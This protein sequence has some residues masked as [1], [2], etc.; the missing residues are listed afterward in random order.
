MKKK[1][2]MTNTRATP[3]TRSMPL[4][5][6]SLSLSLSLSLSQPYFS[7]TYIITCSMAVPNQICALPAISLHYRTHIMAS[8]QISPESGGCAVL[9]FNRREEGM[10]VTRFHSN[11]GIQFCNRF[12]SIQ[13]CNRFHLFS[14]G[15]SLNLLRKQMGKKVGVLCCKINF[16][17]I[18]DE[19]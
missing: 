17:D 6:C 12:N 9:G 10:M 18:M 4:A 11:L 13:F 16:G 15:I 3:N 8:L 19:A 5:P 2:P 7:N 1:S 14:S